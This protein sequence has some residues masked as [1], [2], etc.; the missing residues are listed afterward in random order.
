MSFLLFR[1]EGEAH[2]EEV[3]HL[4]K[5]NLERRDLFKERLCSFVANF[6]SDYLTVDIKE[7]RYFFHRKDVCFIFSELI[8]ERRGDED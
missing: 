6:S 3:G 2:R 8:L 4:F 1:C 7:E 5:A